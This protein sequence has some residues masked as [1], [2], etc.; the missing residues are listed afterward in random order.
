VPYA[1]V[2]VLNAFGFGG[3]CHWAER[4][5]SPRAEEERHERLGS[6]YRCLRG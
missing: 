6:D 2:G 1:S 5:C 4:E 3:K